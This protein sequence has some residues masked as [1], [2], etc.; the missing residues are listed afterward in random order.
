MEIA[1]DIATG[2]PD[3]PDAAS[4]IITERKNPTCGINATMN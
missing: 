2:P 4:K 1:R 3:A